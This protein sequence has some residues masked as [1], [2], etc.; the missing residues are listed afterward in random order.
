MLSSL[1]CGLIPQCGGMKFISTS[2]ENLCTILV[3]G[4]EYIEI[5]I[6]TDNKQITTGA[7]RQLLLT[8][9]KNDYVVSCDDDDLVPDYYVEEIFSAIQDGFDCVEFDGVITTDGN[10][11][12][13]WRLRKAVQNETIFENGSPVYI[14]HINHLSPVKRTIALLS[15]YPDVSN[16]EDKHYSDGLRNYL[17]TSVYIN[18]KM[19]H[20]R[21][22]TTNKSY[23]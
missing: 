16:A 4:F 3:I 22:E 5:I 1:V 7:K 15:P 8:L 12:I 21:Y 19:Y 11:E 17:H 6:A 23:K 14:R 13:E 18:K 9:A 10:N 20:Y 2:H